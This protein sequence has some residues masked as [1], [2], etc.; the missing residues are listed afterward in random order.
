MSV[1]MLLDLDGDAVFGRPL[2][3]ERRDGRRALLVG[4]DEE[5]RAAVRA[6]LLA[7]AL[8]PALALASVL[9]AALASVLAAA[10]GAA[11]LAAA[12]AAVLAAALAAVE[13]P[14]PLLLHALMMT[15]IATSNA[16]IRF[17]TF[18]SSDDSWMDA[19]ACCIDSSVDRA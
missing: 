14:P 9:A 2:L 15:I 7:L 18:L 12:L 19:H 5:R 3:G 1:A 8:A 4:P 13:A 6:P 16:P 11:T 17:V 10:L